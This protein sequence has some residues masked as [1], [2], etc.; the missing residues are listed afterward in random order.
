VPK[1]KKGDLVQIITGAK[2]ERG[3]DRGKQGKVLSVDFEKNRVIVEGVN[4]I[5]VHNKVGQTEK[6]A[7]TGGIET[8]EASVHLSNVALVDPNT[9]KPTRIGSRVEVVTKGGKSK[10]VRTRVAVKSGKE[11]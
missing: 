1:I 7:R 8:R 11:I 6:G 2:Q 10:T 3:G 9:K 5:T 4:I